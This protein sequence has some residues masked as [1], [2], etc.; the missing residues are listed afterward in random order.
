LLD[1]VKSYNADGLS[2][3]YQWNSKGELATPAV[4]G[5]EVSNGK[6]LPIGVIG[7]K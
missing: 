4:Y 6:I 3:H 5:Y 2:K 7:D 1:F